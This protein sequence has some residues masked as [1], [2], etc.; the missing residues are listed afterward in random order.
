[1]EPST[2]EVNVFD[3]EE[4][5]ETWDEDWGEV[6]GEACRS[7]FCDEMLPSIAACCA[8]DMENYKFD[9]RE[10]RKHVRFLLY[11][12]FVLLELRRQHYGAPE[13]ATFVRAS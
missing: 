11:F 13:Q 7:L 4:E 6:E 9:F 12:L 2:S 8:F 3:V 5:D 1:M 10:Y